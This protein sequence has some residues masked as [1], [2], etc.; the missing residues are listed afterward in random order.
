M[1]DADRRTELMKLYELAVEEYRFQ[2]QLNNQRFQWYV[3]VDM[4]LM[5]VGAGL[6]RVS[7]EGDG[8]P[9]MATVFIVGAVLA[10]FTANTV[11]RQVG[12]QH[13]ARDRA[14]AIVA[15][16]GMTEFAIGSTPGWV[17]KPTWWPL[18]VRLVN[19]GLLGVLGAVHVFGLLYVLT[20]SD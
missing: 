18:K 8:R 10:A 1:T 7:T 4:A 5:T 9:L 14:K 16:L 12:Y 17:G 20:R 15:E 19:Y 2:V 13:E 6:L 3:T 11:A